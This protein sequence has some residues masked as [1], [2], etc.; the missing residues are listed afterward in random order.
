MALTHVSNVLGTVNPIKDIIKKAREINP[1]ICVVVDGA[2]AV[3]HIPVD[4]V[5][6]DCDF[7]CF[8]GHKMYGPTGVG[9]LYGKAKRLLEMN[10]VNFGGGMIKTVDL[11][12]STWADGPEKFEAGTPP[13]AEVI[14]L[15]AAVDFIAKIGFEEIRKH[16]DELTNY[17]IDEV[18]KIKWLKILGM[19]KND[20]R[21][22]VVSMYSDDKEIGTSHDIADI[23]GR[24]FNICVRAGHHCAMPLHSKY[25]VETGTVRASMGI[26]N[27]TEDIDQFIKGLQSFY[28]IFNS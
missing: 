28:E 18:S 14:G 11:K 7:Y 21:L 6:I 9:V 10:A 4:V 26:Y 3:A 17:L 8:S 2:Q 15:G 24:K 5:D 20:D 19:G 25:N 27:T 16:E 13:I 12:T 23:L 22:G 1:N